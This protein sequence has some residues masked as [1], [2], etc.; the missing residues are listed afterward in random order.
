MFGKKSKTRKVKFINL[1]EHLAHQNNLVSA[2]IDSMVDHVVQAGNVAER[3]D[4]PE[5]RK[6][7]DRFQRQEPLETT[8]VPT[9]PRPKITR[10]GAQPSTA[11]VGG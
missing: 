5:I 6:T 3:S 9:V 11:H 2:T 1:A 10:H 4:W 7:S 8:V